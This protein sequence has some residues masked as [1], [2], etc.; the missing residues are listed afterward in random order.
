EE[1]LQM[2]WRSISIPDDDN[3]AVREDS[4]AYARSFRMYDSDP[5]PSDNRDY[6]SCRAAPTGRGTGGDARSSRLRRAPP[7][8]GART[9]SH[10]RKTP[11]NK[12]VARAGDPEP[13][14]SWG[15]NRGALGA[16]PH[17]THPRH[18]QR[19]SGAVRDTIIPAAWDQDFPQLSR[20][21]VN[22]TAVFSQADFS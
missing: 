8:P 15:G 9:R 14:H 10:S 5:K 2:V 22:R 21:R 16:K 13:G 4:S 1:H 3:G 18:G 6:H 7:R 11:V 12:S 19:R 17:S 20:G